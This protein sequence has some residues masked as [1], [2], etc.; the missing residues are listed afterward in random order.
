VSAPEELLISGRQHGKSVF[1]R[2][3]AERALNEGKTVMF[4]NA[5]GCRR[6]KR[7]GRFDLIQSE[8]FK[9]SNE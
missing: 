2:D 4:V 8:K 3:M 1:Q 6:V 5:D 9:G 7:R